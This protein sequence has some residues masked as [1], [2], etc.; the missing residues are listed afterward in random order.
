MIDIMMSIIFIKSMTPPSSC[1]PA[2]LSVLEAEKSRGG[3]TF[4]CDQR[5]TFPFASL[6]LLSHHCTIT[7]ITITITTMWLTITI[8]TTTTHLIPT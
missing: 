3:S 7:I 2:L 4:S 1:P 5:G 6:R 8:T